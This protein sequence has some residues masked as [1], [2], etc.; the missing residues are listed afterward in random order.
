M[1]PRTPS[2]TSERVVR[3]DGKVVAG[4]QDPKLGRNSTAHGPMVAAES[5]ARCLEVVARSATPPRAS[6]S[7]AAHSRDPHK[8]H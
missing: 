2:T 6:A 4:V 7:A 1:Q 5:A 8:P 3:M